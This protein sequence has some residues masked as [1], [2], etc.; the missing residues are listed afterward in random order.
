MK[1]IKLTYVVIVGL[2]I[3]ILFL[4]ECGGSKK[5][6]KDIGKETIDTL[7]H[8]TD[9]IRISHT[10][11][12]ILPPIIKYVNIAIATPTILYDTI[13]IQGQGVLDSIYEY[14]NPYEDSLLSGTI[15]S[16]STGL[17]LSQILE[18]TPKFPEYIIRIDTVIINN[19]TV[20]EKKKIKLFIGGEIG[21]NE[22]SFSV[23]P[24]IDIQ[25]KK[26]YM[27][28][29]RYGLVDKTHNIRFSKVLSFKSKK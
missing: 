23:S 20:V 4:Q 28:G 11:T 7:K 24:I 3:Y 8:T 1:N 5:Y 21:G 16:T 15:T 25:T 10:D 22:S 29:Y 27:Y 17:I 12:I 26:G 13:Y 6:F 19:N 2:L 9:T 18:Y 14:V